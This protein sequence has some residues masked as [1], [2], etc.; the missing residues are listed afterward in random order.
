MSSKIG[1]TL[2][3]AIGAAV[4]G[5]FSLGQLADFPVAYVK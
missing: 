5:S 1:N 3:V 2:S 4:I